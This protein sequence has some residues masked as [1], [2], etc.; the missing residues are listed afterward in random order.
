MGVHRNGRRILSSALALGLGATLVL[1]TVPT[2]TNADERVG[3]RLRFVQLTNEDRRE[4]DRPALRFQRRISRYAKEHSLA[5][6]RR[7]YLFHSTDEQ[8]RRVLG[9]VRWSIGGENV[10]VGGSLEGLERA[11]MASAPHRQ[12]ILRREFRRM[13]VGIVRRDDR[14]WVTV[15]FYG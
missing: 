3:P 10:G 7:G 15:I 13:A 14:L 2:A 9:D 4:H 11:F 8:L 5:M 1:G 6:A 12:N